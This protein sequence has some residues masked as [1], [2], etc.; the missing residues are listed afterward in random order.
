ML[1]EFI[2]RE[3]VSDMSMVDP[4]SLQIIDKINRSDF[5]QIVI[6]ADG[7]ETSMSM[8]ADPNEFLEELVFNVTFPAT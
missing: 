6:E 3:T 1:S 5:W 7:I 2:T 4:S 8:S